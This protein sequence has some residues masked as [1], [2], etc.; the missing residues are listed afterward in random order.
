MSVPTNS[1][2]SH[3]TLRWSDTALF[4]PQNEQPL[5]ATPLDTEQKDL[6]NLFPYFGISSSSEESLIA[7][8]EIILN[9]LQ[10]SQLLTEK[11]I[12]SCFS[13]TAKET[14]QNKALLSN[15]LKM[16]HEHSLVAILWNMIPLQLKDAATTLWEKGTI[17]R[18]V[19]QEEDK[20]RPT[21]I[22]SH[23]NKVTCI[24][25]EICLYT[26]LIELNLQDNHILA[27]S[28]DLCNLTNLKF[29]NLNNN[30]IT[31]LP[32]EIGSFPLVD[33][34]LSNNKIETVPESVGNLHTLEELFLDGNNIRSVL[35]TFS[36]LRKLRYINLSKNPIE[37]SSDAISHIKEQ[38][39]EEH[40]S[41]RLILGA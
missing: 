22:V 38:V 19:L 36:R 40:T 18:R 26:P 28:R 8:V 27:I 9:S 1:V 11:E 3:S 34:Q 37:E 31:T 41:L 29:L 24:P 4:V 2:G 14:S 33:L 23:G 7:T 17:C 32:E 35:C 5:I 12:S 39:D 21:K 20:N 15:L 10:T 30:L 6:E 13:V 25:R 16:A